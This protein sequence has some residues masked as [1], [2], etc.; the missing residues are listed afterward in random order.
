MIPLDDSRPF[1]ADFS[2]S[3]LEGTEEGRAMCYATIFY[4]SCAMCCARCDDFLCVT[5][6]VLCAMRHARCVIRYAMIF[7]VGATK[8]KQLT[9]ARS[10]GFKGCKEFTSGQF[11]LVTLNRNTPLEA[12]I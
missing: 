4:A 7:N 2:E 11:V 10:T 1:Q 12:K 8:Q 9:G 6:V 5:R 3:A